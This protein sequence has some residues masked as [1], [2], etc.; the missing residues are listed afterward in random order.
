MGEL[1]VPRNWGIHLWLT[2][3]SSYAL[4]QDHL[5]LLCPAPRSKV[6]KKQGHRGQEIQMCA[7]ASRPGKAMEHGV[8]VGVPSYR[9]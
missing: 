4:V 8:G 5:F 7:V 9:Y 6:C 2:K 1:T 3:P